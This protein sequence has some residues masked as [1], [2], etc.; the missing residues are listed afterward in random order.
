MHGLFAGLFFL[1]LAGC[2]SGAFAQTFIDEQRRA[3]AEYRR[4][5]LERGNNS[6]PSRPTALDDMFARSFGNLFGQWLAGR[7]RSQR[8]PISVSD[9]PECIREYQS[10]RRRYSLVGHPL[11]GKTEMP[12][13]DRYILIYSR[14]D[15]DVAVAAGCWI[16]TIVSS[17]Q[18]FET[19]SGDYVIVGG[20]VPAREAQQILVRYKANGTLPP[21]AYLSRGSELRDRIWAAPE[22]VD[23]ERRRLGR[24]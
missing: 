23:W 8:K 21:E 14:P 20:T 17:A 18:V 15:A 6:S 24:R 10:N 3:S 4:E 13:S 2:I 16:G 1:V 12:P 19:A 11:Q 22:I 9:V 7:A 5:M